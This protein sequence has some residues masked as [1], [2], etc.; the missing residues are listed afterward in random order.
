MR[1][2]GYLAVWRAG[3]ILPSDH[4]ALADGRG[5]GYS[6]MGLGDRFNGQPIESIRY[7]EIETN[8]PRLAGQTFSNSSR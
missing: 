4:R 2:R 5:I 7:Y 3:I 6:S 8:T 1:F